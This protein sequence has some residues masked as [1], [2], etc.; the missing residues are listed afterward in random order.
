MARDSGDRSSIRPISAHDAVHQLSSNLSRLSHVGTSL[1]EST[2]SRLTHQHSPYKTQ[3]SNVLKRKNTKGGQLGLR[4]RALTLPLPEKGSGDALW[5]FQQTTVRQT[6]SGLCTKLP[7]EVRSLIF[8]LVVAGESNVV[9][10]Y[11]KSKRMG[12]WRCR[13]QANGLPC[14]WID[15]CSKSLPFKAMSM[16]ENGVWISG[17][18]T[19]QRYFD[20]SKILSTKKDSDIGALS[21][22]CTC[23]QT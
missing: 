23:R 7:Y 8:E 5:N 18:P 20:R 1:W 9:H 13:R 17:D 11:K 19:M 4:R 22:L 12:H 14:T 6:N 3:R 10:V 2:R 21:L 15:P 16:D